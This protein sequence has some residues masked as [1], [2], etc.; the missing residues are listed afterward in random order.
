M[1]IELGSFKFPIKYVEAELRERIPNINKSVASRLPQWIKSAK[2]RD[3]ILKCIR[4]LRKELS[5][6]SYSPKRTSTQK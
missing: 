6:E 4:K 1:G 3:E 5:D 2:N